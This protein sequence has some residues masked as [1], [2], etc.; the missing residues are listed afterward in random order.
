MSGSNCLGSLPCRFFHLRSALDPTTRNGR[1]NAFSAKEMKSEA[2]E[3][4][5][6]EEYSSAEEQCELMYLANSSNKLSGN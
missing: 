5:K 1:F 4:I 2:A 3:E 6:G